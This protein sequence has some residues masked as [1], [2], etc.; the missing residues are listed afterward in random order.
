[1]PKLY[2]CIISPDITLDRHALVGVAAGFASSIEVIED[3]VLF[4]VSGL[5]RLIG[6]PDRVA[7]KIIAELKRKNLAGQIAV[8]ETVDTAKLLARNTAC[9]SPR[10]SKGETRT[11]EESPLLTRGLLQQELA[12]PD[13]FHQIPLAELGLERDTLNVFSELGLH[14][15]K[16]L[17][18]VP[19]DD[20]VG[21][22]GRS[23][24][25]VIDVIEQRGRSLITPNIKENKVAWNFELNNPVEDFEQLIFLLNH[26]LERLFAEVKYAGFSTEHLFISLKLR[27]SCTSPRVSKGE[28]RT[29]E[30]SPLL[31]RG[32]A[33]TAAAKNYNIKT[34]FPTL[35]RAFWLKLINLRAALDAPEEPI[36]AVDVVAYFAKPRTDQRGLYAVSRP[37][38]ESLLLT[39]NKLKKLVGPENVGV[40]VLV[41]QRIEKP[42]TLEADAMPDVSTRNG[43]DRES[44][45]LTMRK[46]PRGGR[47]SEDILDHVTARQATPPCET[48]KP[49]TLFLV[50]PEDP[51]SPSVV[52]HTDKSFLPEPAIFQHAT[53]GF[54]HFT[55]PVHAEVLVRDAKLVYVRTRLFAGHIAN[56][57]GVWKGNSHWWDKPWKTQEWDIE[58]ENAGI[59]RLCKVNEEW[60]LTGEYD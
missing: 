34:S 7:K 4:D 1:M 23:F 19:H 16:D 35:D 29:L 27:S 51:E 56:F 38:P 52:S 39:V 40:P 3:G 36:T 47:A 2:A 32:L 26:G 45:R 60:F 31:T 10:V 6:K 59:Y 17:Q 50:R 37:E 58:I 11:L 33:H 24:R 9:K 43:S 18:A 49:Q 53:I 22:Y 54:N 12:Q 15:V 46:P 30:E 28:T 8:A 20:L 41:D 25:D 13:M 48:V 42:F 21:R 5:E 14:T 57:S 55:T 44:Q